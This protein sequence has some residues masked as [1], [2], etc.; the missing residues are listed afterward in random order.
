M[1][2]LWSWFDEHMAIILGVVLVAFFITLGYIAYDLWGSVD[3]VENAA[4]V[5]CQNANE[6][7]QELR[8]LMEDFKAAVS[9]NP[10]L[11]PL[12][13]TQRI[14]GYDQI[15]AALPDKVCR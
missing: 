12:Q 8:G 1:K 4:I 10:E 9:V 5:A 13:K 7:R 15:I 11:S 14:Q 6:V 3:N 2:L